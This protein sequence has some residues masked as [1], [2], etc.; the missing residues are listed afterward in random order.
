MP[1]NLALT[2]L[3]KFMNSISLH[4]KTANTEEVENYL[5]EH[6]MSS[7]EY[8]SEDGKYFYISQWDDYYEG[9]D[10]NEDVARRIIKLLGAKPS[11]I[12]Y[13]EVRNAFS[14]FCLG[15]IIPLLNEFPG[16]LDD[17]RGNLVKGEA[18]Q[19]IYES[20]SNSGVYNLGGQ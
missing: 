13:I 20:D 4:F 2:L 12:Y 17:H 8:R 1:L 19:Q 5:R 16:I 6:G 14:R 7:G 10:Y 9:I 18:L 11:T 3:G 15:K